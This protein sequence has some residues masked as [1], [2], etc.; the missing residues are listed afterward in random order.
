MSRGNSAKGDDGAGAAPAVLYLQKLERTAAAPT[1]E[2]RMIIRMVTLY[3]SDK[4]NLMI[5]WKSVAS[6]FTGAR[7]D[8]VLPVVLALLTVSESVSA[9]NKE[10]ETG[11]GE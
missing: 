4:S 7:C 10:S 9:S 8:A 5:S 11:G 2:H 6:Q 3:D 1:T